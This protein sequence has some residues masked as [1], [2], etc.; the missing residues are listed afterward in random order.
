MFEDLEIEAL[1]V[2]PAV[3]FKPVLPHG[4]GA[5]HVPLATDDGPA[6][7]K[8]DLE[9]GP[10]TPANLAERAQVMER[11]AEPVHAQAQARAHEGGHEPGRGRGAVRATRHTARRVRR[12]RQVRHMAWRVRRGRQAR[13]V[14]RCL[15]TWRIAARPLRT[16]RQGPS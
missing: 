3:T 2:R 13:Q 10:A 1:A 11:F 14:R 8:R 16:R 4:V 7:R 9:I 12:V 6:G 5:E 15:R